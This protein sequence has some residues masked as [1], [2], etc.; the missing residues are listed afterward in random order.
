M[1]KV[2]IFD[3]RLKTERYRRFFEENDKILIRSENVP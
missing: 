2:L 1:P 3:L